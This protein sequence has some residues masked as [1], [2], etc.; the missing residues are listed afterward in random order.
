MAMGGP[1]L[2]QLP[3]CPRLARATVQCALEVV[4]EEMGPATPQE[5]E[6]DHMRALSP[7]TEAGE[8]LCPRNAPSGA[9]L[10]P[11]VTEWEH[12]QA[13]LETILLGKPRAGAELPTV[14]FDSV[15]TTARSS[16]TCRAHDALALF[17]VLNSPLPCSGLSF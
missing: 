5:A 17:V 9:I 6:S 14:T 11:L 10:W 13:F 8:A 12:L 3:P 15:T 16:N 4:V 1:S 7:T 2:R